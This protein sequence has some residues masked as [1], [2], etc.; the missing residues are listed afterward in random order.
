MVLYLSFLEPSSFVISSSRWQPPRYPEPPR[1]PPNFRPIHIPLFFDFAKVPKNIKQLGEK[2]TP[3]QRAKFF[4]EVKS[5][6]SLENS[7]R[8]DFVSCQK[9]T[10]KLF[11]VLICTFYT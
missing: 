7:L 2:M 9:Q 5:F 11:F 8:L 3:L 4:G 1:V 6:I 10:N